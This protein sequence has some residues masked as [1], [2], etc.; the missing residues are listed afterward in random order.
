[1]AEIFLTPFLWNVLKLCVVDFI[2]DLQNQ[3]PTTIPS[4]ELL[5]ESSRTLGNKTTKDNMWNAK[6]RITKTMFSIEADLNL[7]FTL[8]R[9]LEENNSI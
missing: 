5:P 6:T 8:A 3:L 1:M 4:C 2:I 7:K 9:E